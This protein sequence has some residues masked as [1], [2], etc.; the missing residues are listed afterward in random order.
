LP[1]QLIQRENARGPLIVAGACKGVGSWKTAGEMVMLATQ[2]VHVPEGGRE[3][4]VPDVP[5]VAR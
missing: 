1:V 4:R 3:V 2:L 5:D